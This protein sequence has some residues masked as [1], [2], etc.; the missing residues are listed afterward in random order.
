MLPGVELAVRIGLIY[1]DMQWFTKRR[2]SLERK[3]TTITDHRSGGWDS[4][5]GEL[6]VGF[7]IPSGSRGCPLGRGAGIHP[8]VLHPRDGCRSTWIFFLHVLSSLF[9]G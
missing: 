3:K 5:P 6:C 8:T 9:I 1:D 4:R 2:V 7:S